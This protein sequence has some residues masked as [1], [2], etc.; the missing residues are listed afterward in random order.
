MK[1]VL[2]IDKMYFQELYIC[3]SIVLTSSYDEAMKFGIDTARK[4]SVCLR[5][6]YGLTTTISDE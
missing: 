2:K 3:G 4:F 1:F 5:D 6:D